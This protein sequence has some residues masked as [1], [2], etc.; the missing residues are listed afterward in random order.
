[1]NTYSYYRGF[2]IY[3]PPTPKERKKAKVDSLI[4][5]LTQKQLDEL[6]KFLRK[7]LKDKI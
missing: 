1:M 2:N 4:D 5:L 6:Y 7:Q 3:T